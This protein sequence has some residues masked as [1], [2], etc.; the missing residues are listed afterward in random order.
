MLWRFRPT[1]WPTVMSIP[2]FLVLLG[3]GTWQVGRLAW[4]EGL[5][6]PF[7]SRTSAPP[8]ALPKDASDIEERE[9]H[10]V[11]LEGEWLN[12]RELFQTGQTYNGV[13]GWDVITPFR[14]KTGEL[15]L[16][17]RGWIPLERK[18][19]ARRAEG[20]IAGPT[21]AEAIIFRDLRRGY[22]QPDNEPA[23][24]LWFFIDTQAMARAAGVDPVKPYLLVALRSPIPGGFPIGGEIK[25][26]LRNEHLSYA[27]TWYSLALALLVIYGLY[28]TKRV[29]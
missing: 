23:R 14:T 19:P 5:I 17:D 28:H 3:L 8:I 12:D 24:N 20:E 29:E 7:A 1:L 25:V 11:R 10:R 13:A 16:V 27:I 15:V 26:A 21:T 2:A 4:K 22:F 6:R 9:Y 18:D